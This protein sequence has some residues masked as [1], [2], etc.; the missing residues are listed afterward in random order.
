[1]PHCQDD[2]CPGYKTCSL[3]SHSAAEEYRDLHRKSFFTLQDQLK[4]FASYDPSQEPEFPD[5]NIYTGVSAVAAHLYSGIA[6]VGP[7]SAIP[8]FPQG[9]APDKVPKGAF[10]C[11]HTH[12]EQLVVA[13]RGVIIGCAAMYGAESVS[14]VKV[15]I[16]PS[17][18]ISI[19]GD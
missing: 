10:G 7:S 4:S 6:A 14:G 15:I 17:P 16:Q 3:P 9:V 19:H 11:H 5:D 13:C 18:L 1:M 12:N 8:A 2:V